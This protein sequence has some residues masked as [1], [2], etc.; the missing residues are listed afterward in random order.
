[1]SSGKAEAPGSLKSPLNVEAA[2][3]PGRQAAKEQSGEQRDEETDHEYPA[4]E[5]DLAQARQ[6]I[7]GVVNK[8]PKH[9]K[10]E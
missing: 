3:M 10:Y 6:L 7:A 5:S 1:M 2:G 9:S 4:V 8:A